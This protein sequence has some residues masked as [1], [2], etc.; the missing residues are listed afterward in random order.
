MK[1]LM[2]LA[3]TLGFSVSSFAAM[4]KMSSYDNQH[5]YMAKKGHDK[6]DRMPINH[7]N[8]KKR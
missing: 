1:I 2:I 5:N 4:D 7:T 8:N 6:D 3:L